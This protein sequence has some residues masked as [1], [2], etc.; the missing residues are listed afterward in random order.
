M[1]N[2]RLL[3][4]SIA[5][6]QAARFCSIILGRLVRHGTPLRVTSM[7]N[8]RGCTRY[9]QSRI[10]EFALLSTALSP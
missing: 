2:P 4:A 3:A 6:P 10:D 5:T 8:S 7:K 9:L 1:K